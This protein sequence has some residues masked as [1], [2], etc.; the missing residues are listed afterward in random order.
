MP[1]LLG[2]LGRLALAIS[3]TAT[4]HNKSNVAKI[5]VHRRGRS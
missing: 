5:E 1:M 3:Q 2:D 4:T